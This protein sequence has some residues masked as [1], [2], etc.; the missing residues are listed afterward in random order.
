MLFLVNLMRNESKRS[1]GCLLELQRLAVGALL[2]HQLDPSRGL[3]S[4]S[5]AASRWSARGQSLERFRGRI[6]AIT[7]IQPSGSALTTIMQ[8]RRSLLR[9]TLAV[10][11]AL[12]GFLEESTGG[13]FFTCRSASNTGILISHGDFQSTLRWP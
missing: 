3:L 12:L 1:N 7:S 2:G 8:S 4:G 9:F 10:V 6:F 13:M 5:P 11:V